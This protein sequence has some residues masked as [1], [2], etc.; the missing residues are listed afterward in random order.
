MSLIWV[1]TSSRDQSC[2]LTIQCSPILSGGLSPASGPCDGVLA[3]RDE[4]R[5]DRRLLTL[6][7]QQ[8]CVFWIH[9]L[10]WR[11]NRG[12]LPEML[13]A[14]DEESWDPWVTGWQTALP[15]PRDFKWARNKLWWWS[16]PWDLEVCVLLPLAELHPDSVYPWAS[17]VSAKMCQWSI[18]II[19]FFR[20][21]SLGLQ[22]R[23]LWWINSGVTH[24][25][26]GQ[27]GWRK[28][29]L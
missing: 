12:S 24:K 15:T 8:S 7:S 23:A 25:R 11:M 3:V 27:H 22:L 28:I 2:S 29:L 16:R 9:L 4:S 5:S 1:I 19:L 26:N 13:P 21:H 6:G 18:A 10:R 17:L 20:E 14:P